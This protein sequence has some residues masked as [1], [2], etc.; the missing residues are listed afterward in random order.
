P[1]SGEA[2]IDAE[3]G[4]QPVRLA[5]LQVVAVPVPAPAGLPAA[6]AELGRVRLDDDWLN[7]RMAGEGDV[8]LAL[9]DAPGMQAR[10]DRG[11]GLHVRGGASSDNLV[12]LDGIPVFSAVH[13]AGSASAVNPDAV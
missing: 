10:G 12:L 7:R 8:L 2:R 6:D 4:A 5:T 13:Y 1:D 9:A 11:A 3:L